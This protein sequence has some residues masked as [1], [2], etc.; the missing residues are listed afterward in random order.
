M[1]NSRRCDSATLRLSLRVSAGNSRPTCRSLVI[2]PNTRHNRQYRNFLLFQHRQAIR[3]T[4]T[5]RHIMDLRQELNERSELHEAL[6]GNDIALSELPWVDVARVANLAE[7]GYIADEL[8]GLGF[9]TRVQ[10]LK[11]FSAANDR[12]S[13]HYLIRVPEPSALAAAELV[14]EHLSP[15]SPNNRTLLTTIRNSVADENGHS[16]W[17]PIASI[18][19]VSVTSFILG[20]QLTEG[21]AT[22]RVPTNALA[23]ALSETGQAFVSKLRPNQAQ[24][25]LSFDQPHRLWTLSADRDHDGVFES[26]RQFT[27]FGDAR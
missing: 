18:V 10:P 4:V 8:T 9:Q 24:Y 27:A 11:E 20:H 17:K 5:M 6:N 3:T 1:T 2:F 25:Q 15:D 12:W 26:S 7:A 23:A 19:L 16:A 13:D 22:R 21:P 14:R